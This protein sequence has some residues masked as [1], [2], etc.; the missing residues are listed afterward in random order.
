MNDKITYANGEIGLFDI[1]VDEKDVQ[2][3]ETEETLPFYLGK[4]TRVELLRLEPAR[5]C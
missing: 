4:G 3:G 5:H 2:F 1:L